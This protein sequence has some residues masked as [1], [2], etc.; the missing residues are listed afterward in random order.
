[1]ER[2]IEKHFLDYVPVRTYRARWLNK[3][4]PLE[5]FFLPSFN[6]LQILC[7]YS[8]SHFYLIFCLCY[9]FSNKDQFSGA[10]EILHALLTLILMNL[11][12]LAL[13]LLSIWKFIMDV[14]QS[15]P[16]PQKDLCQ[17]GF[18]KE[19]V[20]NCGSHVYQ[21][22]LRDSKRIKLLTL[23]NQLWYPRAQP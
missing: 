23:G 11:E 16:Q 17:L 14:F 20:T 3:I 7:V 10:M 8:K 18:C 2:Q 21:T 12:T 15:Q 6:W 9:F 22:H 13:R 4:I 19:A 5:K 1:M